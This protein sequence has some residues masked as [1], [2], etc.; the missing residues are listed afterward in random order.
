MAKPRRRR[1]GCP[2]ERSMPTMLPRPRRG[3]PP[4]YRNAS[5]S[6]GSNPIGRPDTDQ[7]G[8]S[9][10][11][12]AQRA[13]AGRSRRENTP[14]RSVRRHGSVSA[15]ARPTRRL[16]CCPSRGQ[17]RSQ[18]RGQ[19][20]RGAP[21]CPPQFPRWYR[22]RWLQVRKSCQSREDQE[23]CSATR[24]RRRRSSG[25]A[26]SDLCPASRGGRSSAVRRPAR[27]RCNALSDGAC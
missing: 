26:T 27:I 12:P 20:G 19:G 24:R 7:R 3:R 15:H 9:F 23:R 10:D 22:H 21:P 25:R 16:R 5:C 1:Q 4:P 18:P 11:R 6:S 8:K 17:P 14:T 13:W 2:I